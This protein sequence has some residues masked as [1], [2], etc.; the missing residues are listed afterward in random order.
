[1]QDTY[2]PS[3]GPHRAR[4]LRSDRSIS[5]FSGGPSSPCDG[6]PL[7]CRICWSDNVDE[8]EGELVTPCDCSGTMVR[9]RHMLEIQT[10]PNL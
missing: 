8:D 9:K 2:N 3:R 7:A 4:G 5:N 6:Q 10:L 1:M